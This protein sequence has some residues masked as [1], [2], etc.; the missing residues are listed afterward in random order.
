MSKLSLSGA[1]AAALL[2]AFAGPGSA[3]EFK[4]GLRIDATLPAD[5]AHWG[6]WLDA[7]TAESSFRLMRTDEDHDFPGVRHYRYQQLFKGVPVYGAQVVRQ[8]DAAGV[9]RTVFGDAADSLD[10]DVSPS[11]AADRAEQAAVADMGAGA[12]VVNQP[13][14]VVLP[15]RERAVLAYTFRVRAGAFSLMRYFVDAHSG[16]VVLRYSDLRSST[17]TVGLGTGTF[18]E[19]RKLGV[20]F[21]GGTYRAEDYLRP[22]RFVTYDMRFDLFAYDHLQWDGYEATDSD[23]NWT[24]GAVVDAHGNAEWTYDYY[25]ERH[26]R[27]GLDDHNLTIRSFV[28]V[29]DNY[30]NA[31]WDPSASI[32]TYGDGGFARGTRYV[33]LSAALDVVA[34][35]LTHGV[36]SNTWD[37]DYQNEPGA[38]NEA[39]SD[40]MATGVEFYF[41]EAGNGRD[42]AD[43]YM[44]EDLSEVFDPPVYAFRSMADPAMFGDADNYAVRYL[45]S[46]DYGGVHGNSGIANQAYYLLVEGGTNRVSGLHVQG[47]GRENRDR[48]EKIFYRG[49][50]LHMTTF[51][52]FAAAR[53]ATIQAAIELYGAGSN[54]VIQTEA[55][56]TAVGVF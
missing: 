40:I 27:R 20:N 56:W 55:A 30:I 19:A 9:T 42:M 53:R 54:E 22:A 13:T 49:F 36:T 24:D 32:M 17:A 51:S 3:G 10:V 26:G 15:L 6:G 31:F 7:R 14:L 16:A 38:L 39:F 1:A 2:L 25:F 47:L 28:H 43:Y 46:D 34:H 45:G 29:V 8:V 48:A 12:Q 33:P 23:N 18:G 50:T 52:N 11:V 21:D 5:A 35:E 44:G 41:Q 37:G 4:L